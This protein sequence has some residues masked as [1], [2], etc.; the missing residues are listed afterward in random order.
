MRQSIV[1]L[2]ATQPCVNQLYRLTR[3]IGC[4]PRNHRDLNGEIQITSKERRVATDSAGEHFEPLVYI[5][6]R[7]AENGLPSCG[8]GDRYDG[9]LMEEERQYYDREAKG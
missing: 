3:E 2:H 6:G 7:S 8:S 5:E 9:V 4:Y 1:S